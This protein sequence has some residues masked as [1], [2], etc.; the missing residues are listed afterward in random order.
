MVPHYFLVFSNEQMTIW[1]LSQPLSIFKQLKFS[2]VNLKQI[3]GY[4]L[5]TCSF[6]IAS[7]WTVLNV[8]IVLTTSKQSD[9][10]WSG[11]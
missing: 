5:W 2:I 7:A 3:H 11:H 4:V 6:R 9:T 1:T 10:E 8:Y